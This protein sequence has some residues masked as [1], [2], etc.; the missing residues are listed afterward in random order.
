MM[1]DRESAVVVGGQESIRVV[2]RKADSCE[3]DDGRQNIDRVVE[4]VGNERCAADSPSD[5]ELHAGHDAANGDRD[6][7][8]AIAASRRRPV[9]V[10]YRLQ[11]IPADAD[12]AR[13]QDQADDKS[14]ERFNS[15][16]SVGMIV[17]GRLDG[18]D[19]AE[20][21]DG[22]ASTSPA[23]SRPVAKTDDR[24]RDQA[25]DDVDGSE[26][27]ARRDARQGRRAGPSARGDRAA[28]RSHQ[29][30]EPPAA[31]HPLRDLEHRHDG[32]RDRDHDEPIGRTQSKVP[33]G[34]WN[35]GT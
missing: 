35:Q 32:E 4:G 1:P 16:V 10:A 5:P 7:S 34:P 6:A 18:D 9:P 14:R 3:R 21:H 28:R 31:L 8:T 11:G 30:T 29:H 2:H 22:D 25:D 17:I 27:R 23:N 33:N 26:Q 12:A 15:S 19:H 20:Q 13:R 24:L